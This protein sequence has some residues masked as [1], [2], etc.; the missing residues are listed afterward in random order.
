[1]PLK[2]LHKTRKDILAK[3]DVLG[4]FDFYTTIVSLE[5]CENKDVKNILDGRDEYKRSVQNR[6]NLS[7]RTYQ[8]FSKV[9][10]V[11]TH[12]YTHFLDCTSTLWGMRY[13]ESMSNAYT[14][15]D[16]RFG[17]S[18]SDFHHAKKFSDLIRFTRLPNYYTFRT[19]ASDFS[20]PWKYKESIGNR[21]DN[22]G[23]ISDKPILFITFTNAIGQKMV[24]APISTLSVLE[25]SAMAQEVQGKMSLIMMLGDERTVELTHYQDEMRKYLYN[26]D[27][28]EYSVCAQLLAVKMQQPDIIEVFRACAILCRFVLNT[29]TSVYENIANNFDFEKLWGTHPKAIEF[30]NKVKQGLKIHE[31]GFL[32]YLLCQFIPYSTNY[33]DIEDTINKAYIT[34]G[35]PMTDLVTYA[36][37]DAALHAITLSASKIFQIRELSL[38]GYENFERI[39]WDK[40]S[41]QFHELNIPPAL[42]GD[43]TKADLMSG[44]SNRLRT[45]DID[46]LYDELV[47]GQFWVDRFTEACE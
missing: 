31:P 13:L 45:Y 23:H 40:S 46:S 3:V 28:T 38:S 25:C 34:L 1:M 7:L 26:P 24:R 29:P 35:T 36:K 17:G 6:E 15:D 9:Y 43:L 4:S 33:S 39:Q 32:F 11:A 8:S 41:I 2:N 21:F 14:A 12:E 18:E 37:R 47:Q 42:L 10:P 5:S 44:D 30:A 19:P 22:K 27:L 20:R 16:R